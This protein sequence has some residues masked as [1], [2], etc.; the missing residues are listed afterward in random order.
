MARAATVT[1]QR[2]RLIILMSAKQTA[3][4]KKSSGERSAKHKRGQATHGKA[5][6]ELRAWYDGEYESMIQDYHGSLES[7]TAMSSDE[8]TGYSAW[9]HATEPSELPTRGRTM[10]VITV[11]NICG[12]MLE[13]IVNN[14]NS[15]CAATSTN[16]EPFGYDQTVNGITH[17][18][19]NPFSSGD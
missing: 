3:K 4:A 6:K 12:K 15:A 14:M 8:M 19:D 7:R 5:S 13:A 17:I 11:A 9:L 2:T 1:I 16:F 18:R 10:K